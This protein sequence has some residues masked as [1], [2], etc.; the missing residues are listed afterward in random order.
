M[1]TVSLPGIAARLQSL[2]GCD[3]H[4]AESFIREFASLLSHA[5]T[6][7]GAV[8]VKG[9]GS[10]RRI[11]VGK[12]TTVEFA[13]DAALAQAVN[14]PFSMFEPVELDDDM[15]PEMLADAATLPSE[16]RTDNTEETLRSEAEEEPENTVHEPEPESVP[17]PVPEPTTETEQTSEPEQPPVPEPEH[18]P[19]F[20]E[21]SA[22]SPDTPKTEN[23]AHAVSGGAISRP[24]PEAPDMRREIPVTH[25]KIIEKERVVEMPSRKPHHT[26]QL[27]ITALISLTAGTLI[28]YFLYG[29]VNLNHVKSVNISADD[30]QVYHQTAPAENRERNDS[31]IP[32]TADGDSMKTVSSPTPAAAAGKETLPD[33][34]ID[35]NKA[36][37]DTVKSNRFLTTMA[38]HHYGKKKFW[39]YIYEEN[40]AT[41]TDPDHIAPN[42]VVTIPPASKY[43]I[44]S[45]DPHSEADAERRAA[46]IMK[47]HIQK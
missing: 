20:H 24:V 15:T 33:R 26:L 39:V 4:Q 46:E 43:G 28:G 7:E 34:T 32:P 41:I 22:L 17:T 10:F 30:V 44:I 38:L 40:R 23:D 19:T 27:V 5:V 1:K 11:S 31:T 36:V 47:H 9:L 21:A 12:D 6:E 2:T 13:P 14:A 25:E 42:T 18:T 45:G 8:T 16:D 35:A 37:T 29:T 3:A